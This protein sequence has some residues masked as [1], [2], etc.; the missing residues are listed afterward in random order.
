MLKHAGAAAKQRRWAALACAAWL[1][2]CSTMPDSRFPD[3]VEHHVT[4]QFVVPQ[5]GRL[6][7]PASN[8]SLVVQE[9]SLEPLPQ[10]EVFEANGE[11]FLV[12][13]A[14]T[15]VYV[16]CRFRAY[17]TNGGPVPGLA[18]V[19]TGAHDIRNLQEP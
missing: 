19:L 3:F 10:A 2:G 14:G 6:R 12:Y 9:L 18:E 1:A 5:A 13:P 15:P 8:R 11:R 16:R 4:A 17:A 7:V